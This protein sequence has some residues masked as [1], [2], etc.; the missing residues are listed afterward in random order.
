LPPGHVD[1]PAGE[2]PQVLAPVELDRDPIQLAA[3]EPGQVERRLAQRLGGKRAG[4][5]GG[6][7]GLSLALDERHALAEVRR[8]RSALLSAGAGAHD[9]H[10]ESFGGRH[11]AAIISRTRS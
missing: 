1:Q 3:A 4:V 10:V 6:A 2:L 8:L 9:D 5:D 11:D 7:P